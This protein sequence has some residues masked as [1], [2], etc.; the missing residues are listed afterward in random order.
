MSRT[1]LHAQNGFT[2][3]EVMVT[4]MILMVGMAGAVTMINGANATT[5]KTKQREAA[6]NLQRELIENARGVP[7]EQLTTNGLRAALQAVPTLADSASGDGAWTVERRNTTFTVT[8]S[9][10]VVDDVGDGYGDHSSG[11]FCSGQPTGAED[12]VADDFKRI[13]VDVAWSRPGPASSS[14]QATMVANPSDG[15]G[16][17]VIDLVRDPDDAT[18]VTDV[19]SIRF[20][21]TTTSEAAAVRF[22]VDG[23][24]TGTDTPDGAHETEFDWAIDSG[25]TYV[26]DGTYVIAATALDFHGLVGPSRA[27]TVRLNRHPPEQPAGLVGGWNAYREAVDLDWS[28]NAESDIRAYRVYRSD[29]GGPWHKVCET[30]STTTECHD[31]THDGPPF[32]AQ[33]QYRVVALDEVADSEIR[34]ESVPSEPPLTIVPTE[35][36]P[37]PP[38]SLTGTLVGGNAEL[39]WT[40]PAPPN[41]LYP[42]HDPL[43]FRIY[44]DGIAVGKRYDYTGLG[45]EREY[46]DTDTGGQTRQYW[47]TTVDQNYSES[48]P[49]LLGSVT[50]P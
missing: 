43:F 20:T 22:L 1:P 50:L 29:D 8:T 25:G 42:G 49:A 32:A 15:L 38:A 34:R 35:N 14:R 48:D 5:V 45:T 13:V 39:R 12:D 10:C 31:A 6:T 37:N 4:I 2:L 26:V 33:Y 24:I 21:S 23:T 18:I 7:Y 16:P 44:R 27:L 46:V 41:P 11:V 19:A 40:D 9:V 17:P 30:S 3:V 47:V 36:R 28:Q